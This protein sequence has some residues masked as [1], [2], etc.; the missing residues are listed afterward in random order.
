MGEMLSV[1]IPVYNGARTIGRLLDSLAGSAAVPHEILVIN[2]G[3]TDS[4]AEV[5][6][7]HPARLIDMP[8]Q[9]GPAAARNRGAREASGD[10]LV[11]LDADVAVEPDTLQ[12]IAAHFL[13]PDCMALIGRPDAVPINSGFFPTYKALLRASWMSRA[14]ALVGYFETA[15]GAVRRHTFLAV[16]GFNARYRQ[17]TVEDYE[18]GYRLSRLHPIR[19]DPDLRVRHEFPGW[20]ANLRKYYQR[21]AGWTVLFIKRRAFDTMETSWQEALSIGCVLAAVA[22]G[23]AALRWPAVWTV[24]MG[25]VVG[26]VV[27]QR[28]FLMMAWRAEGPLFTL[29]AIGAYAVQASAVVIGAAHGVLVG[30][31]EKRAR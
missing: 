25:C 21:A 31:T 30:L 29:R 6:R 28:R 23:L 26:F 19:F 2:D 20:R 13:D 14:S 10:V 1:I 22:A 12:R 17:A 9:A 8:R 18:F 3:S 11:F 16:G 27:L 7:R 24:V 15:C 4:T 5:V